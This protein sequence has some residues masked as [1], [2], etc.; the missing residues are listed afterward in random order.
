[1]KKKNILLGI[2]LIVVIFSCSAEKTYTYEQLQSFTDPLNPLG[3]Y[4]WDE[5]EDLEEKYMLSDEESMILGAWNGFEKQSAA[6][7]Y[8][9]PNKLFFASFRDHTYLGNPRKYFGDLIGIWSI[10]DGVLVVQVIT[11]HLYE[12]EFFYKA[13]SPYVSDV[14][15][16]SDIDPI[17]YTRKPM[18]IIAIPEDIRKQLNPKTMKYKS[19]RMARSLYS[20]NPLS[21]ENSVS[22][23]YFKHVEEMARRNLTGE[24][25]ANS[26]ELVNEFFGD[27][28]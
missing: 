15:R 7:Y 22:Y 12:G 1:M 23:G 20:I 3:T 10:R 17:G 5:F 16:I 11:N 24:Q 19:V 27:N 14:I 6:M 25:I 9:F 18:A 28:P 13:I 4:F 21:K 2:I 8:F 26:P